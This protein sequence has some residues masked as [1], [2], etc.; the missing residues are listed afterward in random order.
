MSTPA[1]VRLWEGK[2]ALEGSAVS[3]WEEKSAE[4]FELTCGVAVILS[5]PETSRRVERATRMRDNMMEED[6]LERG[7]TNGRI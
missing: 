1:E 7:N 4:S 2:E 3:S 5:A 6:A